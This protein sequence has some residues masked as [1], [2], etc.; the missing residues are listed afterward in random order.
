MLIT[1]FHQEWRHGYACETLCQPGD[2]IHGVERCLSLPKRHCKDCN[3]QENAGNDE[4]TFPAYSVCQ[5]T[6]RQCRDQCDK[7]A[8]GDEIAQYCFVKAETERVKVEDETEDTHHHASDDDIEQIK[9][10]IRFECADVGT[11]FTQNPKGLEC[12]QVLFVISVS[13]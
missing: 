9:P 6:H 13:L 5:I 3:A 4:R 12:F 7:T 10:R 8:G 11:I 2:N 1:V